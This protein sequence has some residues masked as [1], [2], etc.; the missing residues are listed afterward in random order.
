M[1][2]RHNL[3]MNVMSRKQREIQDREKQIL[4]IARPIL[5][6]EGYQ[7]LGMERL[8]EKMQYAKG[9]LYNHFP[10]KEEIVAALVIESLELRRKLFEQASVA[11]SDARIGDP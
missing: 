6:E 7:A 5:L 11:S 2:R 4:A 9:T 8:A 3:V 1:T 10:H